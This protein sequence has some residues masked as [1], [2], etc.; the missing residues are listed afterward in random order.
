MNHSRRV[1][2]S[3]I[4]WQCQPCTISLFS[5]IF[6]GCYRE[7]LAGGLVWQVMQSAI[8]GASRYVLKEPA[9]LSNLLGCARIRECPGAA[10][11]TMARP[12][13]V[14]IAESVVGVIITDARK[15]LSWSP[16]SGD[17]DP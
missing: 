3:P 11:T 17:D 6:G 14:R 7:Y 8:T 5:L 15:P 2:R 1:T 10:A 9:Q 4:A 12:A 16:G 13:S